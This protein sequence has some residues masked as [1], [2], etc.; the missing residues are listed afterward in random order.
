MAAALPGSERA[1]EF[2]CTCSG[3]KLDDV[4]WIKHGCPV[5]TNPKSPHYIS[6]VAE[7][8]VNPL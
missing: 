6:L 2:G 1:K 5:H 8:A 7:P 4:F 3:D